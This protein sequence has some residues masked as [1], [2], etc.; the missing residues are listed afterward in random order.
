MVIEVP[1]MSVRLSE[2]GLDAPERE[3]VHAETR[4]RGDA[5]KDDPGFIELTEMAG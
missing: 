5:K 3:R 4:R 2:S 1:P